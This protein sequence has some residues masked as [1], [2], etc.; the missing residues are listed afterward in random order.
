MQKRIRGNR[1]MRKKNR[2]FTLAELL[3]V[4]AIIAVLVAVSIPIFASQLKKARL[5]VDHSAIR[6][7]YAL[8]QIANT[9][10]VVEIDGTSY[11]YSQLKN[12]Y[13]LSDGIF[14]LGKDCN[15]LLDITDIETIVFP[16]NAYFLKEDGCE[17]SNGYYC[18]TCSEIGTNIATLQLPRTHY[19]KKPIYVV[20]S[21]DDD[22]LYLGHI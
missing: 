4:V 2:G 18:N 15:S 20:Y 11:T 19:K 10:E 9:N 5:A 22:V 6:D 12:K 7:A 17:A 21:K 13:T 3:I 16:E 8:V 14:V 1:G